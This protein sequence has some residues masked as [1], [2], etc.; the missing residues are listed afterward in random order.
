M[1]EVK[2][3]TLNCWGIYMVSS[4][5]VVRMGAIGQHLAESDYD[6]VMLQEIWCQEDFDRIKN[7]VKQ[8]LPYS[9]LFN[10]GI[11]G[12]GTC[13]FSKSVIQVVDQMWK[14]N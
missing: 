13:I 3:F 10:F 8:V 11:G 5:R 14:N 1:V 2:V 6:I 7:I 4:D 12:T 9:Y